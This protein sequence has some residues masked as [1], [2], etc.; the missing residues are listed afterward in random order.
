MK[1]GGRAAALLFLSFLT[2]VPARG[3]SALD[4]FDPNLNGNVNVV[5]VQPDGTIPIG[6]NFTLSPNGGA[7][8]GTT[9]E[10]QQKQPWPD[11]GNTPNLPDS[12]TDLDDSDGDFEDFSSHPS[13]RNYQNSPVLSVTGL[14]APTP[15]APEVIPVLFLP[16]HCP[17][18]LRDQIRERAPP[19]PE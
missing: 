13:T 10:N 14:D 9:S 5:V 15:R 3:Q 8:N 19:I 12:T 17:N 4:G 1:T 11:G 7:P 2:A 6:G 18:C 16:V